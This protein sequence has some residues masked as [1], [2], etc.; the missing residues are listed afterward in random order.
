MD[1][2]NLKNGTSEM[3][4][5]VVSTYGILKEMLS[6]L[7]GAIAF[8]ELVEVCKNPSHQVFSSKQKEYL[9]NRA[10]MQPDGRIHQSVRNIV[11]SAVQ[12]EGLGL[13]LVDPIASGNQ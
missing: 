3:R 10:L 4:I 2:V 1:T 7:E 12:G 9:I 11:L 13:S 6:D 5:L 8:Y